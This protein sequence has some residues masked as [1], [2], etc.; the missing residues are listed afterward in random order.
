V[1]DA[2][3]DM[4]IID[5]IKLDF[6]DVLMSP[7]Q[8]FLES[9]AEVELERTFSTLHSKREITCVPIVAANMAS[10]SGYTLVD[11]LADNRM[12]TALP[13]DVDYWDDRND[14]EW[15]FMTIGADIDD[16]IFAQDEKPDK[17]CIDIANGYMNRFVS[18]VKEAR[19]IL[20]EAIIV[21]GNVCTP[22]ATERLIFAGADIVKVG[23]GGGS[24]CTTRLKTGVGYPQLSAVIECADSAHGL[25]A[26]VMSDGGCRTPADVCKA[27]GAGADFVMLG[28]ML[29]GHD[30]NPGEIICVDDCYYKEFYGMSSHLAQDRHNGGIRHYRSSEGREVLVPYKGKVQDTINDILGGLR[31]CCAYCGASKL[32]EL[33]KRTTFVRVSRQLNTVFAGS[34]QIN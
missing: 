10:V 31:S 16:L 12:F 14:R 25:G 1:A 33:S 30:E 23:I 26:M 24:G 3:T 8:S 15:S 5:D 7:K 9:R 28:G 34:P 29:S 32:K 11:S 2:V 4:R 6:D 20:P 17:L 18:V 13:K 21:A 19:D 27:F 22:E